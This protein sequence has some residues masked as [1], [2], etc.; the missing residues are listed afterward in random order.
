MKKISI[1]KVIIILLTSISLTKVGY[2]QTTTTVSANC[3][4]CGKAVSE[5]A[6]VGDYCPYCGV[7]WG[8]ENSSKINSY[9]RNIKKKYSASYN[10]NFSSTSRLS[11]SS[12]TIRNC[13]LMSSPSSKGI[14]LCRISEN[15]AI[16]IEEHRGKWV[17][18]S[19]F[20]NGY[21]IEGDKMMEKL[22][23][24]GTF[25]SNPN[26]WANY[27]SYMIPKSWIGWIRVDDIVE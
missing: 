2:S 8:K 16:I 6:K 5:N 23:A 4:K 13:K 10:S 21:S 15:E 22:I 14:A 1:I 24:E 7:R 17:K 12:M 18:I 20:G 9:D 27:E 3:G 19:F 26:P 11:V 25:S